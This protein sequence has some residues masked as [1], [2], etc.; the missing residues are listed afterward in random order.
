MDSYNPIGG[1]PIPTQL[2]PIV[3][4]LANQDGLGRDIALDRDWETAS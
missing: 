2:R 4:L 3:D 1:S